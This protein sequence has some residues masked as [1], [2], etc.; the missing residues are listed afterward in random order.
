MRLFFLA[1]LSTFALLADKKPITPGRMQNDNIEI[2]ATAH[3][4]P[5]EVM[6]AV[7]GALD[8]GFVV[9]AV[10]VTPRGTEPVKISRDDFILLSNKDGQQ[11]RP[12][13]P[14]QIAGSGSMVISTKYENAGMMQNRRPSVMGIPIGGGPQGGIGNSG[15]IESATIKESKDADPKEAGKP[16]PLLA[17]LREKI[18]PEKEITEPLSGQLYFLIE[19]KLKLKDLELYYVVRKGNKPGDKLMLKFIR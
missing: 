11:S 7:G 3:V 13:S 8:A 19:G 4:T 9:V 1:A 12:F 6:S 18:L 15:S 16:N 10:T 17:S 2:V 14:T 5:D